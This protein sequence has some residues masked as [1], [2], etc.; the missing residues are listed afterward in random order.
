MANAELQFEMAMRDQVINNQRETLKNMWDLLM[1]LGLD[2][3]QVLDLAGKQGITIED[4][5]TTPRLGLSAREQSPDLGY[6]SRHT[7]LG[8]SPG[9]GQSY[10]RSSCIFQQ[11]QDFGSRSS[12]QGHSDMAQSFCREERSFY[13]MSHDQ[14]PSAFMRMRTS[15]EHWFASRPS[16]LFGNH[17]KNPLDLQTSYPI[18]R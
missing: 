18:S 13:L 8:P 4:G 17:D 7:P 14:S 9:M 12:P 1:G 10:S 11:T 6:S 5:A 16:S 3:R 15:S 2:E